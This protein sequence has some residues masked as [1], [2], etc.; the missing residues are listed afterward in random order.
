MRLAGRRALI[1]GAASGIGRATVEAF[2]REGAHVIAADIT[3]PYHDATT[4]DNP[5][6]TH[7]DITDEGEW[8]RVS[9]TC[10]PVDI[11]VGCAGIAEAKPIADTTL[12]EWRRVVA[13]NLDGG[14]LTVKYGASCIQDRNSGAIVLVGSASGIKAATGAGA[15]CCSKAAL[16]ML[17]RIAA[18]E[19]KDRAIRVNSVSPAGVVT[20]MW[21]KT[22]FWPD[23]VARHGGEQGAW[24]ALGG[25]DPNTPSIQRMAFPEEIA[26]AIVFL[27]SPDSAHMTGADLVVDAGYTL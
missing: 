20:P 16:R 27:S 2:L 13:V 17:V 11:V 5:Q 4:G 25:I 6:F 12:A 22:S 24:A 23:L 10:A 18:L 26:A 1:T 15:Y 19:Y 21:Q 14:F 8:E 7:L 9:S 3:H